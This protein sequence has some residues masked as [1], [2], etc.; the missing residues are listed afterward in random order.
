MIISRVI[1]FINIGENINDLSLS[2]PTAT[3][4]DEKG[5]ADSINNKVFDTKFFYNQGTEK[6]YCNERDREDNLM[7]NKLD[8]SLDYNSYN[9]RSSY[10]LNDYASCVDRK[11]KSSSYSYDFTGGQTNEKT[12]NNCLTE[13]TDSSCNSYI[14]FK[15]KSKSDIYLEF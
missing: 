4:D 12:T 10:N 13:E 15:S 6:I 14:G 3:Q 1:F 11:N 8:E 9:S 2:K 5:S 7:K